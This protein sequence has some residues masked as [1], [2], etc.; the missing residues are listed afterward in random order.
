M[1]LLDD[2]DDEEETKMKRKILVK[3]AENLHYRSFH[4][5]RVISRSPIQ[6]FMRPLR[7]RSEGYLKAVGEPGAALV[8]RVMRL[9][10]VTEVFIQPYEMSVEISELHDWD[11]LEPSILRALCKE[12]FGTD[13]KNVQIEF[14]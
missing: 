5:N 3:Q 14:G 1:T 2:D 6:H 7:D 8:R 12:V 4:I 11:S 10:G 9:P 13:E